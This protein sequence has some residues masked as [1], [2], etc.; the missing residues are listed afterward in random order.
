[1]V[2]E[3]LSSEVCFFVHIPCLSL[4]TSIKSGWHGETF[5]SDAVSKKRES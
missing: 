1:M 3:G 2:G 4:P 5:K